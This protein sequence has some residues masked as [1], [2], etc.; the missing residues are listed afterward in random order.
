MCSLCHD[1]KEMNLDHIQKC[2]SLTDA[3]DSDNNWERWWVLSKLYW[4]A[5][6]KMGDFPLTELG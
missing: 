5:R 1:A 6:R 2:H 3:M 4:T